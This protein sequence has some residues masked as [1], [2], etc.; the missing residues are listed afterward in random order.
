M[1]PGLYQ[2][3]TLKRKAEIA[4]KDAFNTGQSHMKIR[5][6][7]KDAIQIVT[8]F[9]SL[10]QEA[11][12]FGSMLDR[13]NKLILVVD[14]GGGTTDIVLFNGSPKPAYKRTFNNGLIRV[15]Q[16]SDAV[17][18]QKIE[19]KILTNK[20]INSNQLLGYYNAILNL[21][22]SVIRELPREPDEINI[23]GGA[24]KNRMPSIFQSQFKQLANNVYIKDQYVN[25]IANWKKAS[26]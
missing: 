13:E 26:E 16:K 22:V 3:A 18:P 11:V 14:L 5:P 6:Q 9:N 15:Y 1:P 10:Q 25:V 4:Y 17:N 23:I 21:V 7:P 8:Q 24:A 2:K 19:L 20:G 12:L